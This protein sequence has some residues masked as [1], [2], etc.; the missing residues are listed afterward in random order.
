MSYGLG[1]TTC[2]LYVTAVEESRTDATTG[3]YT[4][5]TWLSGYATRVSSENNID[6]FK[7]TD[8]KSIQLWLENYCRANPLKTFNEAADSALLELQKGK[9]Q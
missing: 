8:T 9:A 5:M 3:V 7:G 2:G 4:Y 1:P 6:Y